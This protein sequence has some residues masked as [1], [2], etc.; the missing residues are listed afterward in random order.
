MIKEGLDN[1][2]MAASRAYAVAHCT[3]L[4]SPFWALE[5]HPCL[6][7]HSS[8]PSPKQPP[9]PFSCFEKLCDVACW[10]KLST[11]KGLTEAKAAI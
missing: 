9:D 10:G 3:G 7:S 11:C 8:P 2:R 1:E 6:V 5:P 4:G